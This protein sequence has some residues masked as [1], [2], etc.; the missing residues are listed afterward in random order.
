MSRHIVG[1]GGILCGA[2][3]TPDADVT[4]SLSGRP[5]CTECTVRAGDA[6]TDGKQSSRRRMPLRATLVRALAIIEGA[7]AREVGGQT[8]SDGV[9]PPDA[10]ENALV[11]QALA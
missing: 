10:F 7:D 6:A 3:L 9:D 5:T 8:V 11:M 1:P 2:P 4:T